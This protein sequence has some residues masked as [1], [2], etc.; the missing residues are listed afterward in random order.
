MVKTDD[1]RPCVLHRIVFGSALGL[2]VMVMVTIITTSEREADARAAG[3]VTLTKLIY[4]RNDEQTKLLRAMA[5]DQANDMT[6][7]RQRLTRIETLVK[8]GD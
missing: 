3:D 4:D 2:I 1:N 7:I 6:E 5:R 8:P